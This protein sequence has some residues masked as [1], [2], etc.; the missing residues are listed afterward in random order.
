MLPLWGG[1]NTKL[2]GHSVAGIGPSPVVE[3]LPLLPAVVS[4]CVVAAVVVPLVPGIGIVVA[5]SPVVPSV[6]PG[7][8]PSSPQPPIITAAMPT[9]A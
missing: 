3:S 1:E 5:E 7:A 6:A 2:V 4:T 9:V 8:A